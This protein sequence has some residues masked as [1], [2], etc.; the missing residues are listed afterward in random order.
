M[1]VIKK[2]VLCPQQ[3]RAVPEQFSWIDHRLVRDR[4]I[5][6]KSAEALAL[7][8]LLV[9]V[10]DGAGLS[11]YSDAGIGRL[12]PLDASGLAR[13]RHELI[14]AGLIA[15]EK[16]LYQVLSLEPPDSAAT[17]SDPRL[18][19]PQPLGQILREILDA[20]QV[21]SRDRSQGDRGPSQAASQG[22]MGR[23]T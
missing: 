6:G 11:Y 7:Y 4:H 2:R 15:Y 3:L 13:A 12:L 18:G 1:P 14:R 20:S 23:P 5:A 9:T 8:L 17:T 21:A 10:A 16:P 22:E 19:A